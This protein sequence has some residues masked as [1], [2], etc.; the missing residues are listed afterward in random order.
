MMAVADRDPAASSTNPWRGIPK[1][2]VK[3]WPYNNC[4]V[5]LLIITRSDDGYYGDAT[6][7]VWPMLTVYGVAPA[8][9][10]PPDPLGRRGA[11][12][13]LVMARTTAV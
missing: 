11:G 8:V 7:T 9:G 6:V 4:P 5:L 1:T 2:S 10:D 12:T 3:H 13:E